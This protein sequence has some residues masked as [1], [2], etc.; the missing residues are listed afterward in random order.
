MLTF[1]ND[2]Y[3]LTPVDVIINNR[4]ILS[5]LNPGASSSE[6]NAK[7]GLYTMRVLAGGESLLYTNFQ[8]RHADSSIVVTGLPDK[9]ELRIIPHI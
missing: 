4:K 1:Y 7:P 9:I 3:D 2:L 5:Q 6:F 8:L